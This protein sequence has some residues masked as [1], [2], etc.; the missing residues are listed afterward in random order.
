MEAIMRKVLLVLFVSLACVSI[1]FAAP[2]PAKGAP[3]KKAAL[4][5]TF[6]GLDSLGASA[7]S[8]YGIDFTNLNTVLVSAGLD[9]V[10]F[11]FDPVNTDFYGPGIKF[12]LG[13]K[14]AMNT[15]LLFAMNSY[16]GKESATSLYEPA[17]TS[18]TGI[19][20]LVGVDYYLVKTDPV[21]VYLGGQAG[22][23]YWSLTNSQRYATSGG[24]LY[25]TAV[26]GSILGVGMDCGFEYFI[27]K[28]ISLGARYL[29]GYN[30]RSGSGKVEIS[31]PAPAAK[32]TSEVFLAD[33]AAIGFSTV[34][35]V[36]SVYF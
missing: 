12:F 24:T 30:L 10:D 5:F 4:M 3:T 1:A 35:L 27:F 21:Y 11:K 36:M 19:G 8:G 28:D 33:Q 29:L 9:P 26:S 25:T 32:V 6:E 34:S 14:L 15:S 23:N 2:A 7:Y 18:F 22:Y 31:P 16:T 20:A 17:V 13:S